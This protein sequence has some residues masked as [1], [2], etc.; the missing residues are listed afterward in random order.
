MLLAKDILLGS[1]TL[2]LV[3]ARPAILKAW[4]FYFGKAIPTIKLGTAKEDMAN[5]SN[6]GDT[7]NMVFRLI[8]DRDSWEWE[9]DDGDRACMAITDVVDNYVNLANV[10]CD[11]EDAWETIENPNHN[12][13]EIFYPLLEKGISM[14]AFDRW[15]NNIIVYGFPK[16]VLDQHKFL[17]N[18]DGPSL[19]YNGKKQYF[20]HGIEMLKRHVVDKQ[21][22][23]NSI[24][25]QNNSEK[26]RAMCEIIGWEQ[27]ISMLKA[28]VLDEDV[29]LGLKRKLL[30]FDFDD[31]GNQCTLLLMEN[32]TIE[33]G[34]RRQFVEVISNGITTC[35]NAMAWQIGVDPSIY[36]EG[37]RT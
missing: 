13:H 12:Y 10:D 3:R 22:T 29:C 18:A 14:I 32:G 11:V 8:P 37:V 16:I 24:L 30:Q 33:D 25:R 4:E 7:E 17:H 9:S 1:I 5:A 2:D 20:W 19:E 31:D 27:A 21:I 34:K 23:K 35:H 28:D 36:N 15:N 6:T 26:R